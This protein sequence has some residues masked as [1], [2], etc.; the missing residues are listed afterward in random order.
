MKAII[1]KT[2]KKYNALLA[3]ANKR[4]ELPNQHVPTYCTD[5]KDPMAKTTEGKLQFPVLDSLLTLFKGEELVEWEVVTPLPEPVYD[6]N[7]TELPN[8]Q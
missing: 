2:Q 7:G 8:E 6:H 3:K 1:C 5:A 4:L